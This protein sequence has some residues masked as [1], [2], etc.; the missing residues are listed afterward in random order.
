VIGLMGLCFMVMSDAM[1]R[2]VMYE[3]GW[4]GLAWLG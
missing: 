4:G 1:A 3:E 2:L